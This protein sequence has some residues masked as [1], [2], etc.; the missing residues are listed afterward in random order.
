[1]RLKGHGSALNSLKF[2]FFHRKHQKKVMGV[3]TRSAGA[4]LVL[5]WNA[6]PWED[7]IRAANATPL[8]FSS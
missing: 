4:A 5:V 1:M 8:L 6:T 7:A 2:G 3:R